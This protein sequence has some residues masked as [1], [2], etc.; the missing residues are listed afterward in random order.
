VK[1]PSIVLAAVVLVAVVGTVVVSVGDDR[2]QAAA[3]VVQVPPAAPA[4]TAEQVRGV[5]RTTGIPPR[6]LTAY[7]AAAQRAG[8]EVPRCGIAWN[9]LAGIGSS[10]SSHG[11]FGGATLGADGRARPLIIGVPLDGTGGNRAVADTDGGEL[12]GDTRWDRAV[13]PMQFIPATWATWGAD[14]DGDGRRDPHDIDDAA[15]AAALYLCDAG[16]DLSAS[17][18]WSQAVLT[19][20]ASGAYARKVAR[21]AAAYAE[22]L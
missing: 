12:D 9:T 19:Y 3:P 18:G 7:V 21:T 11:A 15:L 17:A 14:G 13:G 2:R 16:D 22:S 1:R 6:A 10:E 20:N 8:R 4:P 5:S